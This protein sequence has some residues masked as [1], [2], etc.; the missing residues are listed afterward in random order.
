LTIVL[1]RCVLPPTEVGLVLVGAD[2]NVPAE[3]L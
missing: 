1:T 2:E 3:R